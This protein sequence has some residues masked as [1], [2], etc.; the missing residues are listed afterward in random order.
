MKE[1]EGGGGGGSGGSKRVHSFG[2]AWRYKWNER[3][4]EGGRS[5]KP[6][7]TN[8]SMKYWLWDDERGDW[9]SK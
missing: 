6:L 9:G 2:D 7:I 1:G 3:V 4:R 5:C 8:S